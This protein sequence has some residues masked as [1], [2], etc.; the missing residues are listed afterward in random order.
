MPQVLG[1]GGARRHLHELIDELLS[2]QQLLVLHV[3][4]N[5]LVGEAG[6]KLSLGSHGPEKLPSSLWL[7]LT[8]LYA[9]QLDFTKVLEQVHEVT[10]VVR[11]A[12]IVTIRILIRVMLP[13]LMPSM[14][15]QVVDLV[16][17]NLGRSTQALLARVY[18]L[19]SVHLIAHVQRDQF[20]GKVALSVLLVVADV[21]SSGTG[22]LAKTNVP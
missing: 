16:K 22:S 4:L 14:L 18:R 21:T 6:I 15:L 3:R 13:T 20:F 8:T 9:S 7:L 19:A 1:R 12:A 10:R 2:V 5:C 11:R 17:F